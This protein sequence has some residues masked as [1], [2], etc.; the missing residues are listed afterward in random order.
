M[1]LSSTLDFFL[2]HINAPPVKMNQLEEM[3]VLCGKSQMTVQMEIHCDIRDYQKYD[4]EV[5][6]GKPDFV[7]DEPEVFY[8]KS[9][10]VTGKTRL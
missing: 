9:R 7:E 3:E 6:F 10:F 1:K 4:T 2:I 8:N 5:L